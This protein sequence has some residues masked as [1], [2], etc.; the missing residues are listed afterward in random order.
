MLNLHLSLLDSCL[1]GGIKENRVANYLKAG[2]LTIVDC[3][4]LV[5]R[6][7]MPGLPVPLVIDIVKFSI[8]FFSFAILYNNNNET[9]TCYCG[10]FAQLLKFTL[11]KKST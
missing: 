4:F 1:K 8:S 6:I 5:R 3:V 2:N 10:L 7:N 9:E 11:K